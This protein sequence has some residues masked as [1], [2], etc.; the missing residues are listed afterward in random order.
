MGRTAVGSPP[1]HRRVA[2]DAGLFYS[3]QGGVPPIGPS[4]WS[5]YASCRANRGCGERP[6]GHSSRR[7]LAIESLERRFALCVDHLIDGL[8]DPDIDPDAAAH[9]A[10][11][12]AAHD[13]LDRPASDPPELVD[14]SILTAPDSSFA[15]SLAAATS[16][17]GS[18]AAAIAA[19]APKAA[20]GLP[21]LHGL[22][23]AR[24]AI[25]LDFDGE[26]SNA[27]YDED[28]SPSTFNAG[29]ATSIAEA[30]R[31]ISV[32]FAPFDVDVTT[33]K[34]TVPFVWHVSSPS[35]SGGYSYVGMFPNTSPQSFNQ[36]ADARTRQ[37]GIAHEVGHNFGLSHQSDYDLLG[38]KTNEYSSGYD[39][40]HGPIMGVDYAQSV[41]K[42]FIGHASGSAM[43]CRTTSPSSPARSNSTSRQGATG[44]APT[45]TPARSPRRRRC[46]C[47]PT[48]PARCQ[49]SS[50]G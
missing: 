24:T 31:Q 16:P 19:S 20:N 43:P 6:G 1:G 47:P 10:A 5:P 42:W 38:N 11:D 17:L 2:A 32:Y 50:S 40:L 44:S 18:A 14:D 30:W 37:S 9:D 13:A 15:V 46:R 45:T 22:P 28:G 27:P 34:P 23:G 49:G 26:G 29:E 3:R 12:D 21:L 4:F 33:E 8:I 48:A 7:R 36:S 39:A 25:Y 35:V 41:H